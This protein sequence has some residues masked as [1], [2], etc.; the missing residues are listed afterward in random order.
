MYKSCSVCHNEMVYI[1]TS[2]GGYWI[3]KH[4]QN[5]IPDDT[6]NSNIR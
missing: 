6:P 1:K 5:V 4:C 2:S 3:C